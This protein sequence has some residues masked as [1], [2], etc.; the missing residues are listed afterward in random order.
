MSDDL[1]GHGLAN[2]AGQY[3]RL[4]GGLPR[5][6]HW[7]LPRDT[8]THDTSSPSITLRSRSTKRQPD[9]HPQRSRP[10]G[11]RTT[12]STQHPARTMTLATAQITL[13]PTG[14]WHVSCSFDRAMEIN[15][16]KSASRV[17]SQV[18]TPKLTNSLNTHPGPHGTWTIAPS[19][20]GQPAVPTGRRP[21]T[22]RERAVAAGPVH[23]A[24]EA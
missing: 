23:V 22:Q 19:G 15:E 6:W 17:T 24:R 21:R 8:G 14:F 12:A 4:Q 1:P 10:S 16:Q 9:S 3:V 7:H 5:H 13:S 2:R 20:E 11:R 18:T